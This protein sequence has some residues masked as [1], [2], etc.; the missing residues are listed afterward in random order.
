MPAL[1]ISVK[2]AG[3][4]YVYVFDSKLAGMVVS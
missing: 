4:V 1:C 3:D 2:D